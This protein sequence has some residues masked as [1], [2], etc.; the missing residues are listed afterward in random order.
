M[1]VSQESYSFTLFHIFWVE[2][3]FL[4][5]VSW[6]S[7]DS[8]TFISQRF[9]ITIVR[10]RLR[11]CFASKVSRLSDTRVEPDLASIF[12][13]TRAALSRPSPVISSAVVE[14]TVVL[15]RVPV[16]TASRVIYVYSF[17][18][19]NFYAPFSTSQWATTRTTL[20]YTD[21]DTCTRT[22]RRFSLPIGQLGSIVIYTTSGW[23]LEW[24]TTGSLRRFTDR[25]RGYLPRGD[26]DGNNG[27]QFSATLLW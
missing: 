20:A 16:R 13:I 4:S 11:L 17:P 5:W 22:I 26:G 24:K 1:F 2:T 9:M 7:D 23:L 19:S 15:A 21:T 27:A 3:R 18:I 8:L 12:T 10:A 14:V 6:N 25:W